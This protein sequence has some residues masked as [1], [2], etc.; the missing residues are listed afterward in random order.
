MKIS[1]A[2]LRRAGL[3]GACVTALTLYAG[4][5]GQEFEYDAAG[6][7]DP[8]VKPRKEPVLVTSNA[9]DKAVERKGRREDIERAVG[10]SRIEGVAV[11]PSRRCVII[12]DAILG[13]GDRL[14]S[15]NAVRISKI[16]RD[17]IV[18]SLGTET[19]TKDLREEQPEE[20]KQGTKP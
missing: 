3:I 4:T 8:M 2:L 13:E 10:A 20:K 17:K 15:D 18:F 1:A 11:S 5:N 19:Y 14:S 9:T 6:L 16:E 12:N 7:R